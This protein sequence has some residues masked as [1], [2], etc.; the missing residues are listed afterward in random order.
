M[1][2]NLK[3]KNRNILVIIFELLVII[4]G[5]IGITFATTRLLNDRTST[6]IKTG[7]YNIDYMGDA[8]VAIKDIEPISD[9]L[10]DYNTTENV[11]RVAFS[12]RGVKTNKEDKLIY[13]VMLNEMN[14]DCSLLN[15]YTKWNLYKNG[16]LISNGSLDPMFDGNVLTDNMRLTTIQEDL[17]KYNEDYD[18]YVLIFW[19]SEA[20]DDLTTCELVDQSA[21]LNSN[22]SMKVFIALYAGEKVEYKRV[23]NLDGTCANKPILY[24]N[25]LPVTYSNNSWVVADENNSTEENLWYNYSASR[26]ANSVVVSNPN[27][28]KVGSV[29]DD[30]DVLGYYVWI[31]R[32]RYKL[33][34]AT[35]EVT[36]SYNA[37]NNGIE[38]NFE[39][40]LN[41]INNAENDTYLT[42]P[43]FGDNLKGFWISKYELSKKDDVYRSV[44]GVSVYTNDTLD[45]YQLIASS[46]SD[47]YK[48]GNNVLSHMVSN[49][50]WG[51]TL[52][53]SHSKYGLCNSEGCS[54]T[55]VNG[56]TTSGSEKLDTTT[57]NNFGVYDMA[58]GTTEYVLGRCELGTATKE[59]KL[60]DG[61]T[62]YNGMGSVSERD[63]IL[64]GGRE[65]FYFGDMGMSSAD[66]GTRSSLI[67]K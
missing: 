66:Y 41:S 26:W 47:S 9:S 53:L 52:Y 17:P 28:Y 60:A 59:V 20:C 19:I 29:I 38:I 15:K 45:N 24:N 65:M 43:V 21:I 25:M 16:K 48:L 37:Y 54:N 31:P 42:H 14:I 27:K 35:E 23:P 61:N 30:E 64:R 1:K 18:N 2:E 36:D 11:I 58:G 44:P 33:W 3:I 22:M 12:L 8:S 6:T 56:T 51:A 40:G 50:E 63:Y 7:E 34:N 13:D 39:N 4:L 57:R 10:V 32:F 46:L 49:L 62:W 55:L 67:S 5:I